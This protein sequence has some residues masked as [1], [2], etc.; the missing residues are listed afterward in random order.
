MLLNRLLNRFQR[1]FAVLGYD[2]AAGTE[3]VAED[4]DYHFQTRQIN[5]IAKEPVSGEVPLP[6]LDLWEIQYFDMD[7]PLLRDSW[8][9]VTKA[10]LWLHMPKESTSAKLLHCLMFPP[11]VPGSK[12]QEA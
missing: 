11:N 6:L 10:N 2:P 9:E 12:F 8:R 7:T 3:A 5:V 1:D 4:D